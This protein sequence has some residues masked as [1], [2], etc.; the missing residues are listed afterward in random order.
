MRVLSVVHPIEGIEPKNI[1]Y[2]HCSNVLAPAL[3]EWEDLVIHSVPTP[4]SVELDCFPV[5][6]SKRFVDSLEEDRER[7]RRFLLSAGATSVLVAGYA[8]NMCCL[9]SICGMPI[10][11]L[12]DVPVAMSDDLA[13][14]VVP[15]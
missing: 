14:E 9:T 1:I 10:Q 4:E 15:A 6:F 13:I 12:T 3:L 2:M 5:G 7:L 8:A 11:E